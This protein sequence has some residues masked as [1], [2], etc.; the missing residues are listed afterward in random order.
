LT[1]FGKRVL[2]AEAACI[3]KAMALPTVPGCLS[4]G[5]D[6]ASRLVE[7]S[8]AGQAQIRDLW[9][10]FDPH[11]HSREKRLDHVPVVAPIESGL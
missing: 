6:Y 8:F 9:A 10:H 11:V 2:A 1:D 5:H 3:T 7:R 4:S